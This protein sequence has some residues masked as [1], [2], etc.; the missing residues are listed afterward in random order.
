VESV[1][2]GERVEDTGFAPDEEP[3]ELET[4]TEESIT[5]EKTA[6]ETRDRIATEQARPLTGSAG[7]LT[8]DM[9]GEGET[10]LFNERRDATPKPNTKLSESA[11]RTLARERRLGNLA[12]DR[13]AVIRA[14]ILSELTG[15]KVP[16]SKAGI[17]ALEKALGEYFGIDPKTMTA[18]SF[19]DAVMDAVRAELEGVT[20]RRDN[21]DAVEEPAAGT[22]PDVD[23]P[24]KLGLDLQPYERPT[25]PPDN[26]SDRDKAEYYALAAFERDSIRKG[27]TSVSF[28]RLNSGT[29]ATVGRNRVRGRVLAS[30]IRAFEKAFNKKVVFFR[31]DGT[32]AGG[33]SF[34]LTPNIIGINVDSAISL[35]HLLG[36]ELSHAIKRQDRN[37]YDAIQRDVMG[38]LQNREEYAAMLVDRG[39]D[40]SKTDDELFNDIV[41]NLFARDSKMWKDLAE[42]SD[43]SVFTR[44]AK[45]ANT[46]IEKMLGGIRGLNARDTT[47]QTSD[48]LVAIRDN[49]AKML[50]E[51]EARGN[52]ARE[53]V[54]PEM[55]T[56]EAS[57]EFESPDIDYQKP[58][59]SN[60]AKGSTKFNPDG[61]IT[62]RG[63]KQKADFSTIMHELMHAF[64]GTGYS[65]LS[66]SQ[67]EEL[68]RWAGEKGI[69]RENLRERMK[70]REAREKLARAWENYIA[71]GKAPNFSLQP[72]FD[73]MAKWMLGIYGKMRNGVMSIQGSDID[74]EV[75]AN[76]RAI[77][78]SMAERID[79]AIIEKMQE[80]VDNPTVVE[81]DS[82]TT[83]STDD[84][85][86]LPPAIEPIPEKIEMIGD[87]IVPVRAEVLKP[88]E[89][90]RKPN[91]VLEQGR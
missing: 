68:K 12:G 46:I 86:P 2:I 62:I 6:K 57:P 13:N 1:E 16:K 21:P 90:I 63:N 88:I 38:L 54:T 53:I 71:S 31:A 82:G 17:N 59:K 49:I 29:G 75:P 51:Y 9:F 87:G 24:A 65:T 20:T 44:L 78:D 76:I 47:K 60:R 81:S 5:A 83:I 45:M 32:P 89:V 14:T 84:G 39:Y 7:D 23:S 40:P 15:T 10:P 3:I 28:F 42:V 77:F 91:R 27:A 61:T 56:P 69:T 50:R 30:S 36:H 48:E 52:A 70:S 66:D 26:A 85:S 4:Q 55:A 11:L 41:G 80:R 8:A 64:E 19:D 73:K 25:T 18:A 33:L 34:P 67:V 43:P 37:L 74:V 79:P 72:I 22:E 35:S 58:S